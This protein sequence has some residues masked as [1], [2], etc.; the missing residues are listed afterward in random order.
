MVTVAT[1]VTMVRMVTVDTVDP[2]GAPHAVR[3]GSTAGVSGTRA[4]V[5]DR[6]T[7]CAVHSGILDK[8]S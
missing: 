4:W 2:L 1:V 3:A 8:Q 6:A 5:G 7:S